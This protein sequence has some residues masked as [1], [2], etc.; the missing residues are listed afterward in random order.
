MTTHKLDKP[1]PDFLFDIDIPE[2]LYHY[3]SSAGLMGIIENNNI[4]ATKTTY[5]NDSSE[6]K[7]ALD[8]FREEIAIQKE[9]SVKRKYI[10]GYEDMLEALEGIED[11]NVSVVSFS[12][13][14]DQLSQWRGY[15]KIG[16][17]YS[18]GFDGKTLKATIAYQGNMYGENCYLMPCQYDTRIH[19]RIIVDVI[20]HSLKIDSNNLSEAEYSFEVGV[21]F[22]YFRKNILIVSQIIK[23]EAFVEEDEW[24]LISPSMDLEKTKFRVGK[25]SLI[26]YWE[27]YL[28]II[29][30][31][32]SVII[33]PTPEPNL[34]YSALRNFLLKQE[35]LSSDGRYGNNNL[36]LD[37]LNIYNSKIPFRLI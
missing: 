4:W 37:K 2:T 31:L 25:N 35:H 3:T 17:G 1:F 29:D 22:E 23:S 5:L 13:N 6:L 10:F 33:G 30:T 34:S 12:A 26:P 11:V 20:N 18:L 28:N 21:S 27:I 7:L 14:G 19:R 15:S 16:D 8:Y 36:F 32:K 24:R 9:E